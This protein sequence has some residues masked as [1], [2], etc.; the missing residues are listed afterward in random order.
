MSKKQISYSFLPTGSVDSDPRISDIDLDP[1][2]FIARPYS[3]QPPSKPEADLAPHQQAAGHVDHASE[4]TD[5]DSRRT[6]YTVYSAQANQHHQNSYEGTLSVTATAHGINIH[7]EMAAS[8]CHP[9]SDLTD[10]TSSSATTAQMIRRLAQQ[11]SRLRET[12]EAER[13]YL[14]ANRERV[15][16][17]Y[18]EERALMEE[19]RCLWDA[20]K[21]ALFKQIRLLRQRV[22]ELETDNLRLAQQQQQQQH[23]HQ[24]QRHAERKAI[25]GPRAEGGGDGSTGA[26]SPSRTTLVP[27]S[28][29]RNGSISRTNDDDGARGSDLSAVSA[30]H[31][32]PPPTATFARR[33]TD[34]ILPSN[35]RVLH[36]PRFLSAPVSSS[37]YP[38]SRPQLPPFSMPGNAPMLS[39]P[40]ASPP[41]DFLASPR[42]EGVPVI[43]IQA[44]HPELEGISLRAPAV[45]KETF[46]D[47]G[48][49]NSNDASSNPSPLGSGNGHVNGNGNDYDNDQTTLK[50]RRSSKRQTLDVLSV[51]EPARLVMHAGHTPSHSLTHL[52]SAII[53]NATTIDGDSGTLTPRRDAVAAKPGRTHKR[54]AVPRIEDTLSFE[55][56]ALAEDHPEPR[57]EPDHENGDLELKGPLMVKNIPAQD[58]IFFQRLSEKLEDVSRGQDATPTCMQNGE[59]DAGRE[60][61]PVD[62]PPQDSNRERCGGSDS[63][64]EDEEDGGVEDIPL[65]LKRTSNFGAPLGAMH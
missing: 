19:E 61:E 45:Q 60:D 9:Q 36:R 38:P 62:H 53:S 25:S 2:Q 47:S 24:Q 40:F 21:A 12:W 63:Q 49:D 41:V 65:K 59:E 15:E 32:F 39:Q 10:P 35:A 28:D 34:S 48:T 31:I 27:E 17:V 43:D 50:R 8:L 3:A 58:E 64:S 5:T 6:Q 22:A 23:H 14:E 52:P 57:F 54:L 37:L 46:T 51:P 56:E 4:E 11:N 20:E 7:S 42:D 26:I 55:L 44:I 33:S 29:R 16:E 30:S 18:K 13:K 1:S